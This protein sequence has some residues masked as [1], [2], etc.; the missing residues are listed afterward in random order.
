MY[1]GP[2]LKPTKPKPASTDLMYSCINALVSFPTE[3]I[4]YVERVQ[5]C[6]VSEIEKD[7]LSQ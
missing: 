2:I 1:F 5:L 3:T 4:I 6:R 7:A